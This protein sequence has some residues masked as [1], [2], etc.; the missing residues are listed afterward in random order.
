MR[1]LFGIGLLVTVLL[2]LVAGPVGVALA[3]DPSRELIVRFNGDEVQDPHDLT[4]RVA[5]T[6]PGQQVKL[7]LAR[8][9][10]TVT[11][12]P[13]LSVLKDTPTAEDR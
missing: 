8:S 2:A 7:E 13:K 3:A 1:P 9:N 4:R 10:G 5:G 6:P 12:A 11:V